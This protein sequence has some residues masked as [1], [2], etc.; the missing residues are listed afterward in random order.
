MNLRFWLGNM[1][2]NICLKAEIMD[3]FQSSRSLNDLFNLPNKI[4]SFASSTSPPLVVKSG[5]KKTIHKFSPIF[6][7]NLDSYYLETK[8]N[9]NLFYFLNLIL[10]NFLLPD[11]TITEILSQE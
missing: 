6:A 9:F 11:K 2:I 1:D 4:V 7:L 10:I 3:G 5:T 8:W